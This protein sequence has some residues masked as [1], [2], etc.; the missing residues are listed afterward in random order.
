M[1]AELKVSYSGAW[2]LITAAEVKYSGSWRQI[3]TIEVKYSGS[4]RTV[5]QYLS[6]IVAA[7]KFIS[8]YETTPVNAEALVKVDSNGGMY[9]GYPAYTFYETWLDGG[10]NSQVWVQRTIIS[11]TLDTDAGSGRLA[12]TSDRVWGKLQNVIGGPNDCV[13]DLK[14]YDAAAGGNLLDTQRVTL[15][16]EVDSGA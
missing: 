4:W 11:G 8:D 15:R 13:I 1:A 2:R 6:V 7:T 16:V 10:L 12:C 14:F 3:Q 9:A 5:F